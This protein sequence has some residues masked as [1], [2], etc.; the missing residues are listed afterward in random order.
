LSLRVLTQGQTV[1]DIP[2]TALTECCQLVK[3]N[4][5]EG[6][7]KASVKI[8]Y[9]P[10]SNLKKIA[11][12]DV[13]TVTFHKVRECRYVEHV[14][15]DREVLRRIE[16]TK[17]EP[18]IDLAKERARRDADEKARL[19]VLHK[20]EAKAKEEAE[21]AERAAVKRAADERSYKA[22][23]ESETGASASA[24]S[25]AAGDDFFGSASEAPA[26]STAKD[27]DEMD[28]DEMMDAL[29]GLM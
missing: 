10:W 22:L 25:A 18:T 8:V 23:F 1:A 20:K 15:K 12:H 16:K 13:G 21:R 4:S 19:K 6:S 5:I 17:Q 26:E 3:A 7:K 27:V 9:T 29:A 14:S 11:T 28:D 2:E 24:S